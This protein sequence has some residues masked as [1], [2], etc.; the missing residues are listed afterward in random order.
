MDTIP[1]SCSVVDVIRLFW[2]EIWK[3]Q[4]FPKAE[5]AKIGHFKSNKQ[6]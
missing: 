6:F 4:I 3:I 1:T 5:I 2:G